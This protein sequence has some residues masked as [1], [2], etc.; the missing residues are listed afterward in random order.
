MYVIKQEINMV[1]NQT[2]LS[3]EAFADQPSPE[4]GRL[5]DVGDIPGYE[6]SAADKAPNPLES[7]VA[8]R[9]GEFAAAKALA[10][11][12]SQAGAGPEQARLAEDAGEAFQR[13]FGDE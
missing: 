2:E 7:K 13:Q 11:I 9:A 1:D 6:A 12:Q 5:I 4:A 3:E 8:R 10:K